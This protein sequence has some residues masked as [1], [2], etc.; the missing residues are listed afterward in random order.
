MMRVLITRPRKDA[1]EFALALADIGAETFFLP[2]IDICPVA[3]STSLDHAISHLRYYDWLIIT[4]ANAADIVLDRKTA[5]GIDR[6][7]ENLRIAAVGPKTAARLVDGGVTP[8][9]IPAEYISESI[10]AGL[11]DLNDCWVLLPM[12]DIA[13]DALP[14]AI[15][16]ANGIAHVITA[17]HTLPAEPD[18]VGLAAVYE[19][20]DV[21]TF[22]SGSTARNFVKLLEQAG[23][24]PFHLAGDPKI[25]CLG[26]KTAH[27][28][29]ELGF[30]VDIV[31]STYT[32]DALVQAIAAHFREN[33]SHA[34]I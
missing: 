27:A 33:P 2:T 22:T 16:K 34:P 19:G 24:N 9:F 12:A 7:P 25:A 10:L 8:N 32:V 3:D 21:I 20:V 11:G 30:S 13:N 6:F 15:M 28:A 29:E 14:H 4:S 5:L 26:P 31:A 18:P 1:S 23:L 17:Y